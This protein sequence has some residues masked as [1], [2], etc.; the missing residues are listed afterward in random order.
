M[1]KPNEFV[2]LRYDWTNSY[3]CEW[4]KIIIIFY[5]EATPEFTILITYFRYKVI[6]SPIE[7][8]DL[9]NKEKC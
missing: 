7:F 4:L 2:G 3:V 8:K 6:K 5:F 1:F 9:N